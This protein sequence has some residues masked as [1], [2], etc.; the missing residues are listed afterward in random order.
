MVLGAHKCPSG[1]G[2]QVVNLHGHFVSIEIGGYPHASRF[3]PARWLNYGGLVALG[4]VFLG[5]PKTLNL[6]VIFVWE[7]DFLGFSLYKG[8]PPI[9]GGS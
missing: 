3:C 1:L 9:Q 6:I 5:K 7:F 2:L 4:W 8:S